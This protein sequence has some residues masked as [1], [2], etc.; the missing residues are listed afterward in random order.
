MIG[1]LGSESKKQ[2]SENIP[3]VNRTIQLWNQIPAD[4]LGT[5]P[6]KQNNFRK[7]VREVINKAK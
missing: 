5:L 7:R 4:A 6:C 2:I 3:L 1:K